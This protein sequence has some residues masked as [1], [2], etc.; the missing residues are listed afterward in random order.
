MSLGGARFSN[1]RTQLQ[2]N[3]VG[4]GI[5]RKGGERKTVGGGREGREREREIGGE[6]VTE[7]GASTKPYP[8]KNTQGP[9]PGISKKW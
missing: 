6:R 7:S 8:T 9:S 5:G 3:C 4:K 1:L 2:H